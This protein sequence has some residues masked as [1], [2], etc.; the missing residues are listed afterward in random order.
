MNL[1]DRDS[2]VA[3]RKSSR[4]ATTECVEVAALDPAV[5]VRDSKATERGHLLISSSSWSQL[6]RDLNRL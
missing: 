3:W 6:L 1:A 2:D 5:G 4:S